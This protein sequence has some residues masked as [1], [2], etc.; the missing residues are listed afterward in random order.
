M[1]KD[2]LELGYVELVETWGSDERIIE[3]ARM[4]TGGGFVS[5]EP[6]EGHPKGDAGLLA[7]LWKNNHATPFEMAGLTFEVKAPIFTIRE[8]QRHRVPFGYNE[9]SARYDAL[10]P[11]DYVPT[12]ERMMRGGGHL[13]KQAA[14]AE[15]SKPLTEEFAREWQLA[16]ERWQVQGELLY[17]RG[18]NNGVP[19][20]LARC[21]MSVGRFSTMRA[22]GN[23]R[24]WI[25]FLKL[26]AHP[27]AQE[28]IRVYAEAIEEMIAEKFPRTFALYQ[29]TKQ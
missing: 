19:K 3:A 25:G 21:A 1:K 4:S 22:T 17:Q 9:A 16:L 6:Y 29:E 13:T 26:R 14:A 5:W 28:E 15:G 8:W 23:L 7:Y 18:L 10:A 11:D 12:V 27:K 2:L 24:G 20:E